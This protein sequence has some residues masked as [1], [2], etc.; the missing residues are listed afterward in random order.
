MNKRYLFAISILFLSLGVFVHA[1]QPCIMFPPADLNGDC[2]VN[3]E[4]FAFMASEWLNSSFYW[5]NPSTLDQYY[6]Q[7]VTE[8]GYS[9][10]APWYRGQNGQLDERIRIAAEVYKRYPWV[11]TDKAV[12]AAPHMVY[13]THWTITPDG[14]IGIQAN[15]N[16]MCGELA[17]RSLSIIQG[18]TK[19]YAYSGDPLAYIYVPLTVDYILDYCLTTSDQS[20]PSFP[21]SVPWNGAPYG[22]AVQ[23]VPI[24]LDMACMIGTEVARAYKLTGNPRYL[25]NVK[26][27]ADVF[28][29]KCN[30]TPGQDPW[31][32][33]ANP[34]YTTWSNKLTGGTPIIV[35]F[36]D[37]VISLGYN[38]QNNAIVQARDAGRAYILNQLL[39]NWT[40]NETWG[41]Y[42]WDWEAAVMTGDVPWDCEYF[43]AHQDVFTNWR[44]DVRNIMTLIFNRNGVDRNSFGDTYSGAWAFPESSS[45]CGSSL[46]YNQYTYGPT[47]IIYGMLAGDER[48]KEIGRRMVLMATYDSTETGYVLDGLPGENVAAKDWLNLAQPWP[49]CQC[50]KAIGYWPELFAPSRENHIAQTTSVVNSVIYGQGN[51][52]YST[53]DAPTNCVDILRLSFEPASITANNG[54]LGLRTD[55][56]AN[57]YTL[58]SVTGGDYIVMIRH[59]GQTQIVVTGTDQQQVADHNALAYSGT[60][61]VVNR[62]GALGNNLHVTSESGAA[63]AYSFSGNQVRLIGSI[64]SNGGRADVYLDSVKQLTL[65]DCWSPYPKDQQILYSKSGLSNTAHQL[66]IVAQGAGNLVSSGNNVYVNAVQ[67][68]GANGKAEFGQG[69]GSAA[70]QRMI[71]GYTGRSDYV[72]S[73]SNSWRPGTEFVVRAGYNVDSVPVSWSARNAAT[74]ANTA[75]PELYRWGA[76]Y[77]EFWVNLT[78]APGSYY[79]KLLFSDTVANRIQTVKINGVSVLTNFNISQTAG[80]TNIAVDRLFTDIIPKNGIISIHFLGSGGQDAIVKAIEIGPMQ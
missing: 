9:V 12:K 4:D 19:Y 32:R 49:L 51:I 67:Y 78:V 45:C 15:D 63:T 37:E 76:H 25:D 3:L 24:Q 16:W 46:S 58:K 64:D 39:P 30:L 8:D 69:G 70:V 72:D 5:P 55:L 14:T 29:L 41:R 28:A 13:N 17:N 52:T 31:G 71:F 44:N 60:W 80:G 75:D 27:W 11:G 2:V 66:R 10:I 47:F 6:A 18:L 36:L 38:G 26:H 33:F 61:Q 73:L 40:V 50:L 57:G 1:G 56:N 62:P 68:S 20:W 74:I 59:D 23:N 65:V 43:M 42:Y 22:R 54:A 48:M 53:F 34:Q 21:I 35:E 7:P 79:V 77:K